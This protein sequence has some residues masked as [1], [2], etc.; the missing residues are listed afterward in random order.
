MSAAP[1][2]RA[3]AEADVGFIAAI[4]ARPDYEPFINRWPEARHL[5]ALRDPDYRY[6]VFEAGGAPIGYAILAGL[7][8]SNAAIQLV[9]IALDAPGGGLGRRCCRLM[10]AE[11]FDR[12]GAHRLHLDLFEDNRRAEHLYASLGFRREGLLRDAERRG[13]VFRSLT[14]MAILAPEYRA[15]GPDAG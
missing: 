11:V 5:R 7:T 10:M 4:E 2:L 9:R 8:S 14:L 3:A 15:L 13:E 1:T 6:L 12:L